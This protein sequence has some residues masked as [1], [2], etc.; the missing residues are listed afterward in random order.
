MSE[1]SE[2]LIK[3]TTSFVQKQKDTQVSSNIKV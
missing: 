1:K 3:V 2:N